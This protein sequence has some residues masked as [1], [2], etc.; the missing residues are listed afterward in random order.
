MRDLGSSN[1]TFLNRLRIEESRLEPG[2][3]IK[4]GPVIFKVQIDGQPERIEPVKT[5]VGRAAGP[6]TALTRREDNHQR[7][8][9]PPQ[10]DYGWG[11]RESM[12]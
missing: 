11:R 9:I 2:D 10:Q 1:G 6:G 7:R 5:M 8:D 4:V 12:T 3:E